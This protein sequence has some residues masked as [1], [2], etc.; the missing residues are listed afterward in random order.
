MKIKT[1]DSV[2]ERTADG[3][4][5]AAGAGVTQVVDDGDKLLMTVIDHLRQRGLV[6]VLDEPEPEPDSGT[7]A[8]SRTS[9]PDTGTDTPPDTR[10]DTSAAETDSAQV[11]HTRYEDRTIVE[12]RTLARSRNLPVGGSKEELVVRLRGEQA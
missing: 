9:E 6:V 2:N 11:S 10:P 4:V 8:G 12:L 7:S 3:R 5:F 1:V